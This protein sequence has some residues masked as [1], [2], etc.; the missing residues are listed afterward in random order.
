MNN[1]ISRSGRFFFF[2]LFEKCHFR[3]VFIMYFMNSFLYV[4]LSD[5]HTR[6][7]AIYSYTRKF[8]K[9]FMIKN[10]CK[11]INIDFNII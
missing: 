4:L 11:Y 5:T 9:M 7:G 2:V 1:A 6:Y 8:R 10:F 3:R